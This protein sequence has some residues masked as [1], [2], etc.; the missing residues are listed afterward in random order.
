MSRRITRLR[1]FERDGPRDFKKFDKAIESFGVGDLKFKEERIANIGESLSDCA[2]I[3]ICRAN[4]FKDFVILVFQ[5][6][7]L[8]VTPTST[9]A[10]VEEQ[11]EKQLDE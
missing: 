5:G 8:V 7:Y 9:I 1:E 3:S 11:F 4:Y 6:H 2:H 10:E